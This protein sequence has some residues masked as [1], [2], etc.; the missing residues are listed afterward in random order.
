MYKIKLVGVHY[1]YVLL[2]LKSLFTDLKKEVGPVL[3]GCSISFCRGISRKF[4][5]LKSPFVHKAAREQL[6]IEQK[7]VLANIFLLHRQGGVF[8]ELKFN[9][10]LLW[11]SRLV[12]LSHVSIRVS[13]KLQKKI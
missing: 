11:F 2:A 13:R 5:I 10:V 7:G 6:K 8:S 1:R 9:Y 3:A 12:K 4:T